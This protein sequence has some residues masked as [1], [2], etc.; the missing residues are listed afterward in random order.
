MTHRILLVACCAA[1]LC[2]SACGSSTPTS[3]TTASSQTVNWSTMIAPGGTVARTVTASQSGTM[4][5]TLTVSGAPLGYGVGIPAP[6]AGC[7]LSNSHVD[8]QGSTLSVPVEQ[9]DYCVAVYDAGALT[10]P[11]GFAVE[12]QTP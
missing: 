3:P 9:G 2:S 4:T 10:A 7:R 1:A 11:I 5:V 12:I 8:V 6:T